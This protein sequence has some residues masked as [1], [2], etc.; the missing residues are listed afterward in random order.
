MTKVFASS[1]PT[2]AFFFQ[3]STFVSRR[4]IRRCAHFGKRSR[5]SSGFVMP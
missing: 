5:F 4:W 3:Y 2:V 1:G